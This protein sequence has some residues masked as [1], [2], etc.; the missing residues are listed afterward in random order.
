MGGSPGWLVRTAV[1]NGIRD[2]DRLA[3]IVFYLHHP[4]RNGRAID[5]SETAMIAQWKNWRTLI[6]PMVPVMGKAAPKVGP[7][8]PA[9]R[10]VP[11][12]LYVLQPGEFPV[13]EQHTWGSGQ[14]WVPIQGI[15]Q[16]VELIKSRCGQRGYVK[17]LRSGGHGSKTHFRLGDKSV[18]LGNIESI[19]LSLYEVLPYFKR[20]KSVIYLD[21]CLVGND[22]ALVRK[23][24]SA[25][26]GV[27]VVAPIDLQYHNEGA[28]ELEGD[29]IICVPD[30]CMRMPV[31]SMS[32]DGIAELLYYRYGGKDPGGEPESIWGGQPATG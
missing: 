16:L 12:H 32:P 4:E 24:S 18:S 28:P 8:A 13:S 7:V 11:V 27:A 14:S 21:N 31:R 5:P 30:G 6:K 3:S 15:A 9:T 22:Q 29:A 2:V 23:V 1:E 10:N 20:G 25:F 19:A 17:T 26:G